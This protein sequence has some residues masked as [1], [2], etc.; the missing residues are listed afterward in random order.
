MILLILR[1]SIWFSPMNT[2]VVLTGEDCGSV[3]ADG[4][5]NLKRQSVGSS[6]AVVKNQG[7]WIGS[8]SRG[9]SGWRSLSKRLLRYIYTVCIEFAQV[10]LRKQVTAP[11]PLLS[12]DEVIID[13]CLPLLILKFLRATDESLMECLSNFRWNGLYDWLSFI[14]SFNSMIEFGI[15]KIAP[16][17][18]YSMKPKIWK[19]HENWHKTNW[20]SKQP[21]EGDDMQINVCSPFKPH[22]GSTLPQLRSTQFACNGCLCAGCRQREN[23]DFDVSI[24]SKCH[25]KLRFIV[26]PWDSTLQIFQ[27]FPIIQTFQMF[28]IFQSY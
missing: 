12:Q 23:F 8:E 25:E 1:T 28:Q 17:L 13:F 3:E 20:P 24:V 14:W 7:W 11:L 18:K 9:G 5:F 15:A 6:D 26:T 22:H 2:V 19:M 16:V 27:A 4:R 21:G 10:N